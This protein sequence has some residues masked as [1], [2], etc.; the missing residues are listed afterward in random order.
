MSA[1]LDAL[2]RTVCRFAFLPVLSLVLFSSP[3]KAQ[4]ISRADIGKWLKDYAAA[5]P[6]FKPGAVLSAKD[7]ERMRPFLPPG[8]LEQLNFPS[9][10]TKIIATRSHRPRRDYVDCTERYQAQVRLNPDGTPANHICGQAFSNAALSPS[11]PLSG[12]KAAWNFE[13]RWQN[14]GEFDLAI[15]YVPMHF[16]GVHDLSG[17]E[18]FQV[19]PEA[20]LVGLN[21]QTPLPTDLN[22]YVRGGGTVRRTFSSTYQRLYLSHLAQAAD[23][24]GVLDL[25]D[26]R[27]F[28][29]KELSGFITPYDLRGQAFITYR[30][31]DFLRADDAW[32][33]DPGTRRV[34]R[35]SAET[36]SDSFMGT[37]ETL[38]D[39]YS[40]SGHVLDW[41]WK[42]L[43]WKDMLCILDSEHTDTH[44]YGPNGDIPDDAWSLRRFA[45]V[46][47]T[48]KNAGNVYGDV[49]MFWDS[50]TWSP[51]MELALD[52]HAK[53]WRAFAYV[54]N[55]S[56]DLKRWGEINLGTET[57]VIQGGQAIDVQ[58]GRATL[59]VAF[60]HGSPGINMD[61]ANKLFD[62]SNLEQVH[63]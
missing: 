51:W 11:D 20:W 10:R 15:A 3:A 9:F 8:Y 37:D 60:G 30:Y 57:T 59:F 62:P 47:R 25:P 39:F 42:F 13:L 56:E 38:S 35:V 34:R 18:V 22:P 54:S 1:V 41:N 44:T 49:I 55:W 27:T 7:L 16:G 58:H 19:P 2:V 53:L 45:V 63:R 29:W 52:H 40:F 17:S 43:G 28:F 32:I 26:A 61:R 4:E 14:Y 21:L 6:D 5:R 12:L 36:K 46:E 50:E 31:N 24:G 33:Y 23:K 48:P